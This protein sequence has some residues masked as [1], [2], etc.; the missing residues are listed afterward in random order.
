[1]VDVSLRSW[2][3][4]VPWLVAAVWVDVVS[5]D[6]FAVAGQDADVAVVDEHEDVLSSV[7]S[8]DGEVAEFAGVAERDFAGLVDAVVTDPEFAGVVDRGC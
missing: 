6:E 5:G 7:G 8:S 2:W 3:T 1:M 4:L